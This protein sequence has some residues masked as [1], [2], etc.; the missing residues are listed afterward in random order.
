MPLLGKYNICFILFSYIQNQQFRPNTRKNNNKVHLKFPT[1]I[2]LFFT[3]IIQKLSRIYTSYL[4]E[5]K[6]MRKPVRLQNRVFALYDKKADSNI[7]KNHLCYYINIRI[8]PKIPP[9][10]KNKTPMWSILSLSWKWPS[11]IIKDCAWHEKGHA[12]QSEM[13]LM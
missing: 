9:A 8:S 4:S 6:I 12:V 1:N 13:W 7:T 3:L 10:T 5:N 2:K 11:S